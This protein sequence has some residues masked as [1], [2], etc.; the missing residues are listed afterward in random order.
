MKF[1]EIIT[2]R[3]IL[4]KLT[5]ESFDSI[6]SDMSQDEQL[7]ILGLN[8]IEKLLE[9]KEKYK[10]GLSTHNK[11]FLYHQLIDKKTNVIIG[12]CG[13]HVWYTDHNRAE[14]GYELFDDSYKGQ[15]IMSEVIALIV[16]YG[17]NK[18]NLERIEAFVSPNNTPSIKLLKRMK[19]K[20]EGILKHH[21]FDN[22][23]MDDSIVFALLKSEYK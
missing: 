8:S 7:H 23:K 22:N 17:F 18:M 2:D 10:K 3:L 5:Q 11:K 13:F 6:Y 9:E 4:R 1:E 19:F 12:W 15:G 14:I 16:N 21:Y 20:Q